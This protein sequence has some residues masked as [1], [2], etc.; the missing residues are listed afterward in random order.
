MTN[1]LNTPIEAIEREL[2]VRIKSYSIRKKSGGRG[3]FN[4]GEGIVREYEFLETGPPFP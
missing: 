1:T 2:P 3:K 4:G